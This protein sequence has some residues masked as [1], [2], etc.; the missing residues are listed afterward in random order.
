[1]KKDQHFGEKIT[2]YMKKRDGGA[3]TLYKVSTDEGIDNFLSIAPHIIPQNDIG[4]GMVHFTKS[5]SVQDVYGKRVLLRISNNCFAHCRY[6]FRRDE[7]NNPNFSIT[8]TDLDYALDYVKKN[9]IIRD[10]ILSGGDPLH[11]DDKSFFWFLEELYSMDNVKQVTIDTNVMA[12]NPGRINNS[13]IEEVKRIRSKYKKQLIFTISATHV[14]EITQEF[15]D[16]VFNLQSVG[17]VLRSHTPLLK[18]FNDD[19]E[20]LSDL[21]EGLVSSGVHPYY[22]IHFIP[23]KNNT[24][25]EVSLKNG[26]KIWEKVLNLSTG[27]EIPNYVVYTQDGKGKIRLLPS[28]VS[29]VSSGVY[30]MTDRNGDKYYHHDGK[31]FTAGT[32]TLEELRHYKN[33]F[34]I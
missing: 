20:T 25:F 18:G 23:T 16:S 33:N 29:E 3:S 34:K 14:S 9:K 27:T 12:T 1:M 6:C 32:V 11:L 30:E 13:F 19:A 28:S 10:V 21:F 17:V 15:K 31:S 2:P 22:L 26:L 5:R 24:H 8:S 7:V 4:E